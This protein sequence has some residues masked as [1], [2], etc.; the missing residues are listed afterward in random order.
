ME[1]TAAY[2]S[3]HSVEKKKKKKK[4]RKL[5]VTMNIYSKYLNGISIIANFLCTFYYIFHFTNIEKLENFGI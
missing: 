5:A 4:K 3:F 1:F 2:L